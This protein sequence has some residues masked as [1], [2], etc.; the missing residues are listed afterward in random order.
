MAINDYSAS[1]SSVMG[2]STSL[3]TQMISK[4][5]TMGSVN[6]IF[7]EIVLEESYLPPTGFAAAEQS[8]EPRERCKDINGTNDDK[9]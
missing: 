1:I 6:S 9:C 3:T 7:C 8:N 4:Q 5:E 2:S